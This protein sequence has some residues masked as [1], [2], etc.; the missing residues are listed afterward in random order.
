[1]FE[2][3]DLNTTDPGFSMLARSLPTAWSTPIRITQP[4]D[5]NTLMYMQDI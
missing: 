3:K 5:E 2:K 4:R 1:M